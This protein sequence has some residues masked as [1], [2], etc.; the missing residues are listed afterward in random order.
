MRSYEEIKVRMMQKY[1]EEMDMLQQNH[2][3]PYLNTDC[4]MEQDRRLSV[5][6]VST[7]KRC[8]QRAM[9]NDAGKFEVPRSVVWR[10]TDVLRNMVVSSF[11]TL[12]FVHP[13]CGSSY[14]KFHL[15]GVGTARNQKEETVQLVVLLVVSSTIGEKQ[16]GH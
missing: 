14:R 12:S 10:S 5:W 7:L 1:K 3:I 13:N 6:V 16:T 2:T 11:L 4:N 15:V 8:V 9:S